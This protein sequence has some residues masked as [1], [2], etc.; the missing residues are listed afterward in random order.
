VILALGR[1][2]R[3]VDHELKASLGDNKL[4][5]EDTKDEVD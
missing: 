2:Q 5:K 4:K 1:G 3:K